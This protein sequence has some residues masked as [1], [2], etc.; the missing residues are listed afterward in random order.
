VLWIVVML[1]RK[2]VHPV[3]VIALAWSPYQRFSAYKRN[4]RME[5]GLFSFACLLNYGWEEWRFAFSKFEF[6]E[7]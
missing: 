7:T 3:S 5:K 1:G 2:Y 4:G 6:D